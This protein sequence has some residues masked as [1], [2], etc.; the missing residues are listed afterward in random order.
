M[1]MFFKFISEHPVASFAVIVLIIILCAYLVY[2]AFAE[3]RPITIWFLTLGKKIQRRSG[4]KPQTHRLTWEEYW[5]SLKQLAERLRQDILVGGF[6]P[7]LIIG[8]SRGGAVLADLLSRELNNVPFLTLWAIRNYATDPREV[9]FGRPE[10][11]YND[12]RLG[13]I[14]KEKKVRKI[15]LVDDFC[16]VGG[17]LAGAHKFITDQLK[18]LPDATR[19]HIVI[20]TAVIAKEAAFDAMRIVKLDYC[21]HD[22]K[23]HLPYGRG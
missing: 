19:Q 21:I 4:I 8:L 2:K 22:D 13:K 10:N 11:P 1:D 16:K 15:L 18:T 17:S 5:D 3:G 12:I 23:T 6:N 9:F 7:D 20:R 14:V